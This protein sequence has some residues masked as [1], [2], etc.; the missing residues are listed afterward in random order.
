MA[1]FEETVRLL[2][3]LVACDTT[4]RTSNLDLIRLAE[5]ETAPQA[6]TC[7]VRPDASGRKAILHPMAGPAVPGGIALSA[8]VDCVP[9]EG[10]DWRGDPF[11]LRRAEGRLTARGACDMK[12][13]AACM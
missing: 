7:R 9:V 4:S 1:E 12:G 6:I 11:A 2:A 8:H 5:A 10:Q 3:R 13:F